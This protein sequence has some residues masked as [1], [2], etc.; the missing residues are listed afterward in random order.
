MDSKIDRLIKLV[1][2]AHR[3]KKEKETAIDTI[4][5]KPHATVHIFN[6]DDLGKS[7]K[8]LKLVDK[9][10][11]QILNFEITLDGLNRLRNIVGMNEIKEGFL[12]MIYTIVIF[13][14]PKIDKCG[15]IMIQGGPGS[16]KTTVS[17]IL[18]MI[19]YG[20][21]FLHREEEI[22]EVSDTNK[23][24]PLAIVNHMYERTIQER[25]YKIKELEHKM[26]ELKT[27]IK[28]ATEAN[29]KIQ[30]ISN[31]LSKFNRFVTE[32]QKKEMQGHIDKTSKILFKISEEVKYGKSEDQILTP[33]NKS[34]YKKE[35][36]I[37]ESKVEPIVELVRDYI[38]CVRKDDIVG[39]YIGHTP[40]KVAKLLERIQG[41]I[42]IFDECYNLTTM[43]NDFGIEAVNMI[44]EAITDPKYNFY[45]IFIGYTD[46]IESNLFRNQ[47]GMKSRL[48][49]IFIIE[50][51]TYIELLDIFLKNIG[52]LNIDAKVNLR[53][54]FREEMKWFPQYGRDVIKFI[55]EY[56]RY[57][58][59]EK[60]V[61]SL[62]DDTLEENTEN[63]VSKEIF[64][65]AFEQY[66]HNNRMVQEAPPSYIV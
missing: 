56:I 31:K 48:D 53:I 35:T 43:K 17:K 34:A 24:I 12:N 37:L 40:A 63:Y 14:R 28:E 33:Q 57:I 32:N 38:V 42:V 61:D 49:K 59:A 47:P 64:V 39:E 30:N 16:G 8:H 45:P 23:S 36:V 15:A 21:G 26:S 41:K 1:Q 46:L 25:D 29:E 44:V 19:V 60:Y 18:G 58:Y 51:Y 2:E 11:K 10:S 4:I 62:L 5:E 65:E 55:N 27:N 54:F 13:G 50:G 66:K 22:P 7:E 20:I 52:T 9:L 3:S 6:I